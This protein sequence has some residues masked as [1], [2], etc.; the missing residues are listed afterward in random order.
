MINTARI[1]HGTGP[2]F[3]KIFID[4]LENFL[5]FLKIIFKKFEKILR[6]FKKISRKSAKIFSKIAPAIE[7][8]NACNSRSRD[9]YM[10]VN[11]S[12]QEVV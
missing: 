4:F 11:N 1:H 9:V 5:K 10:P 12:A 3:N 6:S 7:V 2:I 8:R